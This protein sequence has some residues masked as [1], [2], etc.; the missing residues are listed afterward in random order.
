MNPKILG[1]CM[2]HQVTISHR[3][4]FIVSLYLLFLSGFVACQD[5]VYVTDDPI[6]I[7]IQPLSERG[8]IYFE[9]E[10]YFA[11]VR[12]ISS[13]G[14]KEEVYSNGEVYLHKGILT[15]QR[16]CGNYTV[17]GATDIFSIINFVPAVYEVVCRCI[18]INRSYYRHDKAKYI[19]DFL[20]AIDK[21]RHAIY[22]QGAH[23]YYSDIQYLQTKLYEYEILIT[24][25]GNKKSAFRDACIE[26]RNTLS[27]S[28]QYIEAQSKYTQ[29]EQYKLKKQILEHAIEKAQ[30]TT[31]KN[32]KDKQ[33]LLTEYREVLADEEKHYRTYQVTIAVQQAREREL[34]KQRHVQHT[35]AQALPGLEHEMDEYAHLRA[36]YSDYSPR[37]IS[38]L[39]TRIRTFNTLKDHGEYYSVEAYVLNTQVDQLL[40]NAGFNRDVFTQC[41]GNQYQQCLHQESLE[42]LEHASQ[43]PISSARYQHQATIATFVEVACEYNHAGECHKSVPLLDFCW[44]LLSWG[45]QIVEGAAEGVVSGVVGA[46]RDIIE[47]PVET[48]VSLVLGS[49]VILTYQLSKIVYKVADL[50]VT[51]IM[52]PVAAKEKWDSYLEPINQLLDAIDKKQIGLKE[53]SKVVTQFGVQWYTQAKLLGALRTFYDSIK[54]KAVAYFHSNQS[55]L[56]QQYLA[57]PD[58]QLC[59]VS[60]NAVEQPEHNCPASCINQYEKLKEML[61]VEQFTSIIKTTKHGIQRLIERGFTPEE[62]SIIYKNPDIIRI[63]KDGANAFIKI[64]SQNR[65]NIMIY[66]QK[67]ESV[68]TA[69]KNI[70]LRNLTNL[71]KKYGWTF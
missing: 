55:A 26:V 28:L 44:A 66:N 68:I 20:Y 17:T 53:V 8:R 45:T 39:D 22:T 10:Q 34:Q 65:Y 4:L 49:S 57:T 60:I 63:Q 59:K 43:I 46:A 16:D 67:N 61:I 41:Y 7:S 37:I 31:F 40:E 13:V 9:Q 29:E 6:P 30:K 15:T 64:I 12:G 14:F 23:D 71:G 58:G 35:F 19:E 18:D 42:V 38:H 1:S 33:R 50:S 62:V 51:T 11:K 70:D 2:K 25:C 32:K 69:L 3:Y 24:A 48:G 36:C 5:F 54:S 56:P 47:H 21:K 27:R 52:N